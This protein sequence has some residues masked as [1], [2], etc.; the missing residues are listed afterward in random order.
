MSRAWTDCH[1]GTE[2]RVKAVMAAMK[3]LGYPMFVVRTYDSIEK[4]AKI[5]AQGRTLPGPKVT[6]TRKG[7]HNLKKK[8]KPSARAVDLAFKKQDRF[9]WCQIPSGEWHYKWPWKRMQKI[10][11]ALG[12]TIPLARDKGHLVDPQGQTFKQAWN[13]QGAA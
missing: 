4:Q 8:R 2:M 10:A 1:M 6:W 9:K 13:S 3:C 7:W 5:Y 12:L 11:R